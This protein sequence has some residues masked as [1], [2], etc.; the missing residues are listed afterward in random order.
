MSATVWFACRVTRPD[1][2]GELY[3]VVRF[4]NNQPIE[5]DVTPSYDRAA[6]QRVADK[7]NSAAEA[8]AIIGG[9]ANGFASESR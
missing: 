3:G 9:K 6:M 5:F 2:G 1:A 4:E 7:L 8:K